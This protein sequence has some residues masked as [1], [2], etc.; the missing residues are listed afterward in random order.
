MSARAA[1]LALG[2]LVTES[3]V[4]ARFHRAY[5]MGVVYRP[6]ATDAEARAFA[7]HTVLDEQVT[8]ATEE[9]MRKYGRHA[10]GHARDPINDGRCVV[11]VDVA[12]TNSRVTVLVGTPY[13]DE[14]TLEL[15]AVPVPVVEAPTAVANDD[16]VCARVD[17]ALARFFALDA[18]PGTDRRVYYIDARVDEVDDASTFTVIDEERF[19]AT[20]ASFRRLAADADGALTTPET[21]DALERLYTTHEPRTHVVVWMRKNESVDV[22]WLAQRSAR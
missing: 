2:R 8:F 15:V 17:A 7:A 13:I 12:E 1:A 10:N 11:V 18:S 22:I 20:L 9:H 6:F 5:G 4:F 3:G 16:P 14:E 19:M 21:Y